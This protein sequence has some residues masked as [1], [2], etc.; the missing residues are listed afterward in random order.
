[1]PPLISPTV[2]CWIELPKLKLVCRLTTH[3]LELADFP[4]VLH[5][6]VLLALRW[7]KEGWIEGVSDILSIE[8]LAARR[9]R[10]GSAEAGSAEAGLILHQILCLSML[11]E[12]SKPET[13]PTAFMTWRIVEHT[14]MGCASHCFVCRR[15]P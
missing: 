11:G 15:Y 9:G 3:C 14:P 13:Q 2:R 7:E 4:S 10:P 8:A 1:M 5:L 12:T 6:P